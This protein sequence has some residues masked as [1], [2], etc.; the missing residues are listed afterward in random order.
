MTTDDTAHQDKPEGGLVG[1]VIDA[2]IF[3]FPTQEEM[4]KA[5]AEMKAYLAEK[6]GKA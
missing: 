2:T 5:E 1:I 4:D 3:T 6:W